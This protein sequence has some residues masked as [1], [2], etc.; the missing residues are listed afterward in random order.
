M[1][2]IL[3]HNGFIHSS[4][5][6][7]A[8]A[9][10]VE[11]GVIAWIG[12]DDTAQSYAKRADNVID[13]DGALI[14][15]GFV[16]THV[17]LL[18]TALEDE[19][20]DVSPAAGGT[21]RATV[22]ELIQAADGAHI[23]ENQGENATP[24]VLCATGYDDSTWDGEPLT[25]ADLDTQFPGRPV[26]VPRADLHSAIVSTALLDAC[27]F[28][29]EILDDRGRVSGPEHTPIRNYI[30]D[31]SADRRTALYRNVL[32]KAARKGVVS[33]HECAAPG[34]DTPAG[35]AQLIE[36]THQPTSA[37]PLVVGY[38][39]ELAA[40]VEDVRQYQE[41]VPGLSGLA[42][43]LS[44]DGSFGSHSAALREPYTDDPTTSG[45]LHF[46]DDQIEQHLAACSE[47]GVTAGFHVI[48]DR[49]LDQVL[50][51]A[52]RLVDKDP[53]MLSKM[54]RCGHRLE[55]AEIADE[56]ARG[57][58]VKLGFMV[59]VQPAFDAFW[60]RTG[61]MYEQ[62]LGAQR[63]HGTS[64]IRSYARDGI[65]M[66]FGSDAP[67]TPIDP[68]GAITAA[69]F[70][71]NE[72]QRISARAAFRAHTRGGWR[73]SGEQNPLVGEIRVGAPAHLA[74]WQA[75]ELGVQAENAGRSS[76]STDGRSGSPLLPIM[77]PEGEQPVCL[78]T[79]R[80]GVF[81]HRAEQ[82]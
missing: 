52:E 32:T 28:G 10:Y 51:A 19:A 5:D 37:L 40:T 38:L 23:V 24:E 60:G 13:L 1:T 7:F 16:D 26:Y 82:F 29:P 33:V 71:N 27:G 48:G 21:S 11:D 58:I 31:L 30:R 59:S 50:N 47:A 72:E 17:H 62:R 65:P 15:P 75:Q 39:G 78:A 36:M 77:T 69:V 79:L 6:P 64:P 14:A 46:T 8:Q 76:W 54:R 74:I 22:L 49:A 44:I 25:R 4:S 61:G 42:G 81:I 12:D 9:L 45:T 2:S 66:G 53:S 55:H 20:A 67:V 68:W 35:L 73:L 34:I 43:D 70:H 56:V 41:L 57:R 63:L 18:E 3:F 80:S